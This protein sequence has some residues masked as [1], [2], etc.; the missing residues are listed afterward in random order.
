MTT[1]VDARLA[2]ADRYLRSTE[3]VA[4]KEFPETIV[5]AA[6]YAMFH[7]AV[8]VLEARGIEPPRTHR[9]LVARFGELAKSLGDDAREMGRLLARGLDRRVI[10]DYSVSEV[11]T[12]EEA[13]EARDRAERFVDWCVRTIRR[14]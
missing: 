9:G 6:Y 2:K 13:S 10:G 12:P 3:T 8:A 4:A 11:L 14:R 7:A 1:E 5:T